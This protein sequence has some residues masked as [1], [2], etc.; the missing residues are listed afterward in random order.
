MPY[1]AIAI[2][3]SYISTDRL[4]HSEK[5]IEIQSI[6]ILYSV[7]V[8]LIFFSVIIIRHCSKTV[9]YIRNECNVH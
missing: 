5:T 8:F 9:K 3:F 1:H 7:S 4:V 6:C 2:G